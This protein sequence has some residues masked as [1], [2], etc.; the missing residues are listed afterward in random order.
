MSRLMRVRFLLGAAAAALAWAA[1]AAAQPS[2]IGAEMCGMCHEQHAGWA[3]GG[4][5]EKAKL[6]GERE[7]EGCETCHGPG[8]AHMEEMTTEGIF[9]FAAPESAGE[10]SGRCLACHQTLHAELNFRRSDHDK[11][12]V[13]CD[14]CHLEGG[15]E[16]FHSLRAA[17]E[18]LAGAEPELCFRCHNDQRAGFLMPNHHPVAEGFMGCSECHEPHGA[19]RVRQLRARGGEEICGQCHEDVQGPFIFEHPPGRA[20]GCASCHQPHGSPN[21]K[22]L[23]RPRVEFLCLECHTDTPRF[24]DLSK[25]QFQNCTLCHSRIHGSNLDRL[26]LE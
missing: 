9:R 6:P 18:T 25:A 23:N 11:K 15:S 13:A 8:S 19:F 2:A 20:A 14:E 7:I 17:E 5:H 22:M 3:K 16:K 21:A 4:V 10:R 1:P 26:F 12:R 24:H